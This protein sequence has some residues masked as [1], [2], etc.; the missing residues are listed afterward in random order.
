MGLIAK[1]LQFIRTSRGADSYSEATVSIGG[2][3]V[4]TCEHMHPSGD[5][6]H[7]LANDYAVVVS[8][9]RAGGYVAVGYVDPLNQ[10]KADK[11]EK[12]VYSRNADGE[13]KAE[14]W[15]KNDGG[16]LVN[17]GAGY[18]NLMPSGVIDLNGF[19][20]LPDGTAESPTQ[21]ITPSLLVDGKEIKDHQHP[22]GTPPGDTGT[23]L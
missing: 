4:V 21:V 12:R 7:P 22:A 13:F 10:G 9:P 5:D 23:N 8:I 3:E 19:T 17:N 1:V 16:V 18:I 2:V 20:I 6:A 11:G 15:L 14:V